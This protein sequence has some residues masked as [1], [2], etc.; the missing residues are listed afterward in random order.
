[1][2]LF[3]MFLK[4]VSVS[5]IRYFLLSSKDEIVAMKKKRSFGR[6]SHT[7]LALSVF[8]KQQFYGPPCSSYH[9]KLEFRFAV[10][11]TSTWEV[12]EDYFK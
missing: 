4:V 3:V 8:A 12:I 2:L 10:L 1:M 6:Q 5:V 7:R 11:F 9:H